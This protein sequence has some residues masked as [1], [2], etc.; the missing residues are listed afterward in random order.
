M[1]I[2]APSF[3]A[4]R[5]YYLSVVVAIFICEFFV[6]LWLSIPSLNKFNYF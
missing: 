4:V 5:S 3:L 6:K 2:N 1:V